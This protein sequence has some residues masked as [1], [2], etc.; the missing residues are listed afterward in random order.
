MLPT[1]VKNNIEEYMDGSAMVEPKNVGSD[2][3][4][5]LSRRVSTAR[6]QSVVGFSLQIGVISRMEMLNND[7]LFFMLIQC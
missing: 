2:R 3:R 1:S 4:A 7:E 6:P 5:L